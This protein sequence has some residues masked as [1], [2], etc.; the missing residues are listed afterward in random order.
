MLQLLQQFTDGVIAVLPYQFGFVEGL[1]AAHLPVITIDHHREHAEF[2]SIA[3][4]NY[5][6]A[7]AAMQHLATLGHRRIAFI[8]GEEQLGSA[9]D[10]HRAYD[11]AVA[12]LRL[13]R[14]PALVLRGDHTAPGG[15]DAAQKLMAMK[16]RPTAVFASNDLSAICAMPALLAAGLRVPDDIS[17]VGFDDLPAAS[18]LH[19]ALTTVRQP[20]AEMGRAA[21]NTLLAVIAGLEVAARQVTLPTEL[22]VRGSRSV[23]RYGPSPL[24]A[25]NEPSSP[26]SRSKNRSAV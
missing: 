19:P 22:V 18:Q 9:Q 6:G 26:S 17:I 23:M 4:D 21:V 7:R 13:E 2:P 16:D 8:S 14:D 5:G 25:T 20:I 1:T 15:R 12:I 24:H 11:D 10:R 3:A